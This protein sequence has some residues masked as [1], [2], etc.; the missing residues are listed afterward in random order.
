M[1]RLFRTVRRALRQS[2]WNLLKIVPI[3]RPVYETRETETPVTISMWFWQKVL[4]INGRAYWPVHFTS[5]VRGV[6]NIY[7]GIATCPGLSPGCYIQGFGKI[8]IGDYTQ[9]GPNVGIISSNH[10]PYDNRHHL[11]AKPIR[12]GEYCWIGMGAIIL[13]GVTLGDFTIVGAGAIVTKSFSEGYCIIA[14]N[15]AKLIRQ[16]DAARCVRYRHPHEYYGYIKKRDFP[17]YRAKYLRV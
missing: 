1:R 4:G 15:P 3:T 11:E 12:I 9:I 5:T 16:L 6:Q 10:N 7:A 13:P 14:G 8:R 17:A 2:W